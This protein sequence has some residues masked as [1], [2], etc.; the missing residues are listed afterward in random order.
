MTGVAL[1]GLSGTLHPTTPPTVDELAAEGE[2]SGNIF[3]GILV[4][5]CAQ[6][7]TATQFVVEEKVCHLPS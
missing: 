4:I 6:L 1:V 7:F 3:I 2:S 5:M